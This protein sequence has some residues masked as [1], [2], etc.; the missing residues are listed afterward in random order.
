MSIKRKHSIEIGLRLKKARTAL[1]I[2]QNALAKDAGCKLQ[3]IKSYETGLRTPSGQIL[4]GLA[5]VGINVDWLIGAT[6]GPMLVSESLKS[7]RAWRVAGVEEDQTA[8]ELYEAHA[9]TRLEKYRRGQEEV[10]NAA[11]RVGYSLPSLVRDALLIAL[12]NGMANHSLDMVIG[13]LKAQSILDR[14]KS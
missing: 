5:R 1:G 13:L 11:A 6:D 7:A 9:E 8:A 3:T 14:D 12:T 2:T 10:D 4:A